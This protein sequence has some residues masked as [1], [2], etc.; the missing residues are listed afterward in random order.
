[1]PLGAHI[2]HVHVGRFRIAVLGLKW[3]GAFGLGR[4]LPGA[5][6]RV[7]FTG[8]P[9]ANTIVACRKEVSEYEF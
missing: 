6:D 8:E 5:A 9:T 2:L 4:L 7:P 3:D 1:M